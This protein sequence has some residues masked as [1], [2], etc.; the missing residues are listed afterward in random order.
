[1]T[2]PKHP[3]RSR[4]ALVTGASGGIGEALAL[5]L[6]RAGSDV[7]LV[8][9]SA[10]RLQAVAERIRRDHRVRVE[11][12]VADLATDTGVD[13]VI[14]SMAGSRVDV[15]VANAGVGATGPFTDTT[16]ER[17]RTQLALNCT[18]L[19]RLVHAFLPGMLER[20]VGGV[21]TV[22]STASFQP[23]PGMAV[24][25][26]TKAFVLSFTEALWQETRGSGVRVLALCPGPTETGFFAAA[27]GGSVMESGRQSAEQV[28]AVGLR[29]FARAGGPTVVPGLGN[30]VI[31]NA[32]RFVPRGLMA[33]MSAM[34]TAEH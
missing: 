9:R 12:V 20:R 16:D 19:T 22:G 26:A 32:H 23:T 31:A 21:M 4:R 6:A 18:A 2:P 3:F 8:A 30:T 5:G 14:A 28:A 24:Y 15:L 7:V 34:V 25:G 1:M 13:E 17:I 11:V 33:R 27:G 10:D 29:A